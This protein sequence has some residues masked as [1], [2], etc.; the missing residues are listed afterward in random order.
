ML[1]SQ[2]IPG[3]EVVH[4]GILSSLRTQSANLKPFGPGT[5]LIQQ[6]VDAT[7]HFVGYFFLETSSGTIFGYVTGQLYPNQQ[8]PPFQSFTVIEQVY[9]TGGTGSLS[10]LS[11]TGSGFGTALASGTASETDSGTFTL[12]KR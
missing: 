10:G 12:R 4:D 9:L 6:N 8:V 3:T 1:V 2:E 7:G 5:G 11:G